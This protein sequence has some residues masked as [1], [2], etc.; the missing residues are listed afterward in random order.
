[1]SE[2]RIVQYHLL[3]LLGRFIRHSLKIGRKTDRTLA[4]LWLNS[5]KINKIYQLVQMCLFTSSRSPFEDLD[6]PVCK[7]GRDYLGYANLQGCVFKRFWPDAF[8]LCTVTTKL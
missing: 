8:S 4:C 2:Q 6:L 3:H 1:M 7:V 5:V